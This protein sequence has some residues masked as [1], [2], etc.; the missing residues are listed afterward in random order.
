[1]KHAKKYVI[2]NQKRNLVFRLGKLPLWVSVT[3]IIVIVMAVTSLL[4]DVPFLEIL[5]TLGLV[6]LMVSL[7]AFAWNKNKARAYTF[8]GVSMFLV[9]VLAFQIFTL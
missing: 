6:V 8:L 4:I 9:F 3:A 1:M 5:N 2:I 7:G